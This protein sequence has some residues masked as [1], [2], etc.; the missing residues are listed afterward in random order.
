MTDSEF[1]QALRTAVVAAISD[2]GFDVFK[3]TSMFRMSN[4]KTDAATKA[5]A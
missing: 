5:A 2:V 1:K 4:R 3:K